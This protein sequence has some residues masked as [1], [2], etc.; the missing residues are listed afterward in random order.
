MRVLVAGA[1]GVIGRQLVP[2]LGAVGHQV[3][4]GSRST[5]LD[6]LDHD[7]AVRFVRAAAPDVIVNLL[8]A[9]PHAIDPLTFERDMELT[10]RLRT[11]GTRTL[12][13]AAPGARLIS[14]GLAYAYEPG[15]GPADEET[16]LWRD[17]PAEFTAVRDALLDLE[18]RTARAGGLVLRFG[19]L[20]GPGTAYDTGGS[21]TRAILAG[22]LPVVGEGGSVFSFTS[23]H[24]AATSIVAAL[25]RDLTG[26]LNVVDDTPVTMADWL[27][28]LAARIGAPEPMRVPVEMARSAVGGWGVAFMTGLRGADNAR[29][30]LQLNWRPRHAAFLHETA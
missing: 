23:T 19:H 20:T 2:L 13:E 6:A 18:S 11:E 15:D 29:A 4:A 1:T 9:I 22:R 12:V 28:A 7:A 25:D 10:N 8:T 26:A 3:I 14:Q 16:P 17:P 5:G 27:P 30:R 21:T 24:D